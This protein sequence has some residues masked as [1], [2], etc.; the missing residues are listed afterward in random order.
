LF[1]NDTVSWSDPFTIDTE[2]L[3]EVSLDERNVV[4]DIVCNGSVK[5]VIT[6][7]GN[8][9][10]T[11]RI[12]TPLFI[13]FPLTNHEDVCYTLPPAGQLK[14]LLSPGKNWTN[15][16]VSLSPSGPHDQAPCVPLVPT[17][18]LHQLLKIPNANEEI[19]YSWLSIENTKLPY[20]IKITFAPLIEV[21]NW[22]PY[23]LWVFLEGNTAIELSGKGHFCLLSHLSTSLE[24]YTL[25]FGFH[26]SSQEKSEP[27][28]LSLEQLTVDDTAKCTGRW[29]FKRC[30][31]E[32]NDVLYEKSTIPTG[33]EGSVDI[34]IMMTRSQDGTIKLT[35]SPRLLLMNEL[36]A[37]VTLGCKDGRMETLHH[38]DVTIAC[39]NES[40]TLRMDYDDSQLCNEFNLKEVSSQTNTRLALSSPNHPEKVC[41]LQL[42]HTLHCC[43]TVVAMQPLY[44]IVNSTPHGISVLPCLHDGR[45][46]TNRD[47]SVKLTLS[48]DGSK[49]LLV[50]NKMGIDSLTFVVYITTASNGQWSIPLSLNYNRRSFSLP[51]PSSSSS[52]CVLTTHK[53]GGHH[54]VVISSDSNPRLLITNYTSCAL[55]IR[56]ADVVDIQSCPQIL[57]SGSETVFDPPSLAALYPLIQQEDAKD[58]GIFKTLS[59]IRVQLQEATDQSTWSKPISLLYDIEQFISD[60]GIKVLLATSYHN[61]CVYISLLPANDQ[62]VPITDEPMMMTC[63]SSTNMFTAKCLMKQIVCSIDTGKEHHIHDTQPIIRLTFD[64]VNVSLKQWMGCIQANIDI[65]SI[66]VDNAT[67]ASSAAV[68]DVIAIPRF[69][70]NPPLSIIETDVQHFLCVSVNWV[71][72][73]GQVYPEINITCQPVTLQVDDVFIQ[74]LTHL[75]KSYRLPVEP[76]HL[77]CHHEDEIIEGNTV[78]AFVMEE[79]KQDREGLTISIF[80]INPIMMYVSINITQTISISCDDCQISLSPINL[81]NV[82]SNW[83]EL[84]QILSVHYTSSAL[85]QAGWIIGSLDLLGNPASLINSIYSGVRDFIHLP[86]EGLTRGPGYFILGLGYGVSSLA[87]SVIGGAI[88]SL[89]NFTASIGTN[90]EIL[91][92]DSEHVKYQEM[93]RHNGSSGLVTGVSGLGMSLMSAAAGLVEQP[94]QSVQQSQGV[95]AVGYTKDALVGLGKGLLGVVTKPVGGVCQLVSQTGYG[96]VDKVGWRHRPKLKETSLVHADGLINNTSQIPSIDR[97][98]RSLHQL[99]SISSGEVIYA[100]Q[101]SC[102]SPY[103]GNIV[104]I[105]SRCSLIVLDVDENVIIRNIKLAEYDCLV[106]KCPEQL[107]D[108]KFILIFKTA[109]YLKDHYEKV[110][111]LNHNHCIIIINEFF[112]DT[113]VSVIQYAKR[114]SLNPQEFFVCV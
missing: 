89:T 75:F 92:L 42:N 111:N 104:F 74:R 58:R 32:H 38:A 7:R 14:G 65:Q 94:M 86:Y 99:L 52:P 49:P 71:Y 64:S 73:R 78:P 55:H 22:F 114:C 48:V 16:T 24:E 2:G 54:W 62:P 81:T 25:Q 3:Q 61:G 33:G 47:D 44:V 57:P 37:S 90:M 23:S 13:T 35:I 76:H 68:Y 28:K 106:E 113:F 79:A 66:Q 51:V 84:S 85:M 77:T 83:M 21:C 87:A 40:M 102:G 95:S 9:T 59:D 12:S 88:S 17:S 67:A 18:N 93:L 27:I 4:I 41:I 69:N 26:P 1:D 109:T 29:P 53:H 15:M 5:K 82:Y 96:I 36:M 98:I 112:I 105:T 31:K 110:R 103:K 97:C 107:T 91:S 80:T 39:F 19:T 34:V 46:T 30:L 20:D 43:C 72:S 56:E 8:I 10:I 11:S 50:W 101:G 60:I 63:S 108:S 70:H 6:I 100:V 45:I